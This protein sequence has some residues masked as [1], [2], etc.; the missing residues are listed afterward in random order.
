[1]ACRLRELRFVLS[2]KNFRFLNLRRSIV[3]GGAAFFLAG[4]STPCGLGLHDRMPF[5]ET[6]PCC[7]GFRFQDVDLSAKDI[8]VDIANNGIVGQWT[9]DAFLT[10]AS[11]AKLFDG[12]YPGSTPLC[13]VFLGPVRAGSVSSRVSVPRGTYRVFVQGQTDAPTA[14]AFA[15]D[16]GIWDHR[17]GSVVGSPP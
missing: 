8:Q 15:V 1:M 11:C 5:K 7:G 14:L 2:I 6:I 3:S 17:C 10:S 4:C 9:V 12:P 16:V 13:E